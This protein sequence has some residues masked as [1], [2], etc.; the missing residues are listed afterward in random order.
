MRHGPLAAVF[1]TIAF[2]SL[3]SV[4][5]GQTPTSAPP[6]TADGRPDLSGDRSGGHE[7]DGEYR[8]QNPG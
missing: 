8:R 4:A 2:T 3:S 5:A 1:T 7:P 6:R